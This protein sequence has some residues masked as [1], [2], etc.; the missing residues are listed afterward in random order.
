[1]ESTKP[2][3]SW[4]SE[5]CP[6]WCVRVHA[7]DDHPDDRYHDSAETQV[8]AILAERKPDEGPGRWV[9]EEAE[10]TIVTSRYA[11][12]TEMVTFIGSG[13]RHDQQLSLSPESAARLAA[14]LQRHLT[15]LRDP[16]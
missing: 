7:D 6:P 12:A 4:Q 1:M 3:A 14:A 5:P 15:S 2:R 16:D 9:H 11:D 8:P 13:D 10:V